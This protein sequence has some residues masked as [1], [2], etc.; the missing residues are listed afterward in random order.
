MGTVKYVN[1]SYQ[2]IDVSVDVKCNSREFL[3][4]DLLERLGHG[5]VWVHQPNTGYAKSAE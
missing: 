3:M 2:Q 4:T 5:Q 1:L